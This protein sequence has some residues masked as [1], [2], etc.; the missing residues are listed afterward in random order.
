MEIRC[1]APPRAVLI[2]KKSAFVLMTD[3]VFL[4]IE[5]LR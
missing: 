5:R 1:H 2:L 3:P 4:T